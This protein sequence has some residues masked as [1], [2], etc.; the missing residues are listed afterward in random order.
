MTSICNCYRMKVLKYYLQ[1]QLPILSKVFVLTCSLLG[2]DMEPEKYSYV[3]L[4]IIVSLYLGK[5]PIKF[6]NRKIFITSFNAKTAYQTQSNLKFACVFYFIL[7]VF[8]THE[9]TGKCI[10]IFNHCLWVVRL[11]VFSFSYNLPFSWNKPIK[12]S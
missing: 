3:I 9:M 2:W 10:V 11:L 12:I 5:K 1:L 4:L 8:S 7:C 6:N